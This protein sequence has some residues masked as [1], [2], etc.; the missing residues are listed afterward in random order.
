MSEDNP[1]IWPGYTGEEHPELCDIRAMPPQPSVLKPG[2][3]SESLIRQ[4]FEEGY[5]VIKDFFTDAELKACRAD[6]EIHVEELAQKLYKGGKIK[7][8]YTEYDLDHRLVKLEEEWPGAVILLHKIG[9]LPPSFRALWGNERMLNL[10]EQLLGPDIAGMPNWNLRTKTPHNE[11]TTVPWHQDAGYLSN[12]IYK[13]FMPT[14]WIPFVNTNEQNG[15]MQV[16]PKGHLSGKVGVHQCCAGD[17]WYIMMEDGE[18]RKRLGCT[19]DDAVTCEIPY[20]G[21]LLFNNFIPH[22]SLDNLSDH[23]RWSV[24]LRFKKPGKDNGMFG[25]KPDVIMRTKEDPNMKIDWDTFDSLNRTE[26]QMKSV[27]DIVEV[28]PDQEFDTGVQG[29]WMRKWEITHL[30]KHVHKHRE[31]EKAKS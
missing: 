7:N 1:F 13:V 23:V 26:L 19:V 2:Q 29:P 16:I 25:L 14:V 11:A 18:M 21:M 24:D 27:A 10:M 4:Y 6:L 30:N 9:K 8:L 20:G 3:L 31:M 17:T 28:N 15:C 5:L 12:D 22:R